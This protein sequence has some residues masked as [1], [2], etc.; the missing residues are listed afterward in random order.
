MIRKHQKNQALFLIITTVFISGCAGRT[1]TPVMTTQ[2]GDQDKSCPTLQY[3]MQNTQ[4]EMQRLLPKTDKTGKNVALGVAGAFLLIPWFFMDFTEAEQTEYEA[5]R[6]RYSNLAALAL[7]KNCGLK[8]EQYPSVSDM[9]RQ[10]DSQ[11]NQGKKSLN[12]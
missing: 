2:F 10:S 3:E 4:G 12:D 7:N 6:Q 9:K 8:I 1:P 11:Q 5:Y